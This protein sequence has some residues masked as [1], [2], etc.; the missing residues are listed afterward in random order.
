MRIKIITLGRVKQSFVKA[1]EAEY[2][3]RLPQDWKLSFKEL[4]ETAKLEKEVDARELVVALDEQGKQFSSLEFAQYLQKK[5]VSGTSSVTFVIGG[6]YGLAPEVISRA[7]LKL[8]LAKMTFPF[9]LC[10][11][12]L[13]EQLYRAITLIKGQPYHK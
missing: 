12:V 11:L 10:R 7:D 1:G 8:S 13:V 4:S 2:V 6:A 3:K 5:M 9:Q